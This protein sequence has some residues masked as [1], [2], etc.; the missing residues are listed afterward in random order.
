MSGN[1]W[2]FSQT[3]EFQVWKTAATFQSKYPQLKNKN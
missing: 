1:Y 3:F 2:N